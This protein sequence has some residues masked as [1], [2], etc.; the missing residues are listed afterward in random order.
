MTK[1]FF[2]EGVPHSRDQALVFFERY[3]NAS[4]ADLIMLQSEFEFMSS[5]DICAVERFLL[6]NPRTDGR[7]I[8][9]IC[10]GLPKINDLDEEAISYLLF[11]SYKCYAAGK[12]DQDTFEKNTIKLI[13]GYWPDTPR[14]KLGFIHGC[15]NSGNLA[16]TS[17]VK[18]ATSLSASHA[19]DKSLADQL[20]R[21]FAIGDRYPT[22]IADMTASLE[23][24]ILPLS[25]AALIDVLL[26]E[27]NTLLVI[28]LFQRLVR[29]DALD[30]AYID[31]FASKIGH[32]FV[33]S[34]TRDTSF[35]SSVKSA[36]NIY[37]K[38]GESP[39]FDD[40]QKSIFDIMID[41]GRAPSSLEMILS[42]YFD[43]DKFS[44]TSKY[45]VD[46]ISGLYQCGIADKFRVG[47]MNFGIENGASSKV[48][49][50]EISRIGKILNKSIGFDS[51]GLDANG[52]IS[53]IM[54]E[55]YDPAGQYVEIEYLS[56]ME[57][58]SKVGLDRAH[59]VLKDVDGRLISDFMRTHID[60]SDRM[61]KKEI[62]KLYPQAK[63]RVLEDDLGL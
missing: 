14:P 21:S 58:L 53:K 40:E 41:S 3:E 18:K 59:N 28:D 1:L 45:I 27:A 37:G 30:A 63:G 25:L 50:C 48:L 17:G 47:L 32:D 43:K 49:L 56:L 15:I 36:N 26:S 60:Q 46:N 62:L 33:I 29:E 9:L 10:D 16:D 61:L 35:S 2:D 42:E 5:E 19:L 57:L 39:F 54:V 51:S 38:Y 6:A 11:E 44:K 34:V 12:Y 31:V 55:F 4:P 20:L 13:D 7:L 22:E 52:I 24:A 8:T 23:S